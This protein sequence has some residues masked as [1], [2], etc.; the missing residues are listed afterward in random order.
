MPKR[1]QKTDIS[2]AEPTGSERRRDT[3][4]PFSASVQLAQLESD[5]R[6]HGRVSDLARGGC[7]IDTINP[8]PAG[9]AVHIRIMKADVSLEVEGS[10]S[11]ATPGLGMGVAFM[12]IDSQR[13]ILLDE[14]LQ[15][16]NG[17]SA[18]PLTTQ[19]EEAA[20]QMERRAENKNKDVL[21][22]LIVTL[23][24]NRILT[25]VEGKTLLQKLMK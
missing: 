15:E 1:S 21:N 11:F 17:E 10:V 12:N 24:H 5:T 2:I 20:Q 3:R 6:L 4:F 9:S 18:P 19:A 7:Y 22:D 8:F 13:M 25:N 16:L 14:W 23:I